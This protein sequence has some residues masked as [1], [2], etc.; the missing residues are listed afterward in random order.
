M[1]WTYRI[2]VRKYNGVAFAGTPDEK[3]KLED[4][5]MEERIILKGILE[6]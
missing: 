2:N 3:E 4:L 6:K 1:I 5:S